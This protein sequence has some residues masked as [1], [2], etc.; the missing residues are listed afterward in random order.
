MSGLRR[1]APELSALLLGLTWGVLSAVHQH[2]T[3]WGRYRSM[4]ES[5]ATMRATVPA[6]G[7]PALPPWDLPAPGTAEWLS[8]GVR[9]GVLVIAVALLGVALLRAGQRFAAVVVPAA[10]ALLPT[11]GGGTLAGDLLVSVSDPET[12][13]LWP[14]SE[15]VLQALVVAAPTVLGLLLTRRTWGARPAPILRATTRQ[16]LVRSGSAAL[17]AVVVLL[18]SADLSRGGADTG[19]AGILLVV[20]VAT[21][22]LIATPQSL[23]ATVAQVAAGTVV[24]IAAEF[25]SGM[26]WGDLG[27]NDWGGLALGSLFYLA[28]VAVGPAAVL[29]TPSAGRAWR[30]AFRRGPTLA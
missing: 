2:A 4:L 12:P 30:R 19:A 13:A 25:A 21:G 3:V 22:L 11:P 1:L 24:L 14:Y 28:A 16:A 5:D 7:L 6:R 23:P 20:V 9:S 15:G 18:L 10:L 26:N 27:N 17:A 29:L 8:Y